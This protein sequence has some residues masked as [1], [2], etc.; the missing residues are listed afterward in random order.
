MNREKASL[1]I[2]WLRDE[3][4]EESHNLPD[5]EREMFPQSALLESQP[6][7]DMTL[8]YPILFAQK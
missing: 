5:P 1:D 8:A 7:V 2:F 4:L 6:Q 3:S